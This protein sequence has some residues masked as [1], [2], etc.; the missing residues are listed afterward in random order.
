[1][2]RQSRRG[3]ACADPV[4]SHRTGCGQRVAERASLRRSSL[5]SS[6][7]ANTETGPPSVS[8]RPCSFP[9]HQASPPVR[10]DFTHC[11]RQVVQAK[12]QVSQC[13]L[14]G[15]EAACALTRRAESSP[16]CCPHPPGTVHLSGIDVI[17]SSRI[18]SIRILPQCP[19]SGARKHQGRRCA[20][21][22]RRRISSQVAILGKEKTN[23]P[24]VVR[25]GACS[26]GA[27]AAVEPA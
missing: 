14:A 2:V 15:L 27:A 22:R 12:P 23:A 16:R 20:P 13:V 26:D 7:H 24:V 3:H 25:T 18:D 11:A 9:S 1:L 21:P 4:V 10:V 5:G 19:K 8:R 6:I 17:P